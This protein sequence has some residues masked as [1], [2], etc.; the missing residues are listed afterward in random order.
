MS[1]TVAVQEPVQESPLSKADVTPTLGRVPLSQ[2]QRPPDQ[3]SHLMPSLMDTLVYKAHT[4]VWILFWKS[5]ITN[6]E[7]GGTHWIKV[8]CMQCSG[9]LRWTVGSLLVS[10]LSDAL[11]TCAVH[12]NVSALVKTNRCVS[13]RPP[14]CKMTQLRIPG[15]SIST[16]TSSFRPP[17]REL[18]CPTSYFFQCGP[19][20]M[21]NEFHGL[22]NF[23]VILVQ[24]Q[25]SQDHDNTTALGK[26]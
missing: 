2:R 12:H 9:G 14:L 4:E 16:Q 25:T 6:R 10:I 19:R 23:M 20:S 3:V 17:D 21:Y 22:L 15:T 1:P 24:P 26:N 5:G 18:P 8:I 13:Y 7:V 11:G